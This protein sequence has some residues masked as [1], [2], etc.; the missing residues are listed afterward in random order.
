MEFLSKSRVSDQKF[1]QDIIN[2]D[3]FNIAKL[4]NEKY[5]NNIN[6]NKFKEDIQSEEILEMLIFLLDGYLINKLKL[7]EKI[8]LDDIKTK[9]IGWV[10]V[11]KISA[12]KEEFL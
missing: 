2:L 9:Y 10:K 4:I 12:Y 8:E 5:F 7:N 11:L 6:F 1:I 3:T